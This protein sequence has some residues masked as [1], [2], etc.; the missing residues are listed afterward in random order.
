MSIN[1]LCHLDTLHYFAEKLH[2]SGFESYYLISRFWGVKFLRFSRTTVLDHL[3]NKN[4]QINPSSKYTVSSWST[5]QWQKR[6]NLERSY[7]TFLLHSKNLSITKSKLITSLNI[8]ICLSTPIYTQ[9]IVFP[10][11][12][13]FYNLLAFLSSF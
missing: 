13:C 5:L 1:V 8:V 11:K 10:S 7:F 9:K 12:L 6:S 4:P 2:Q 3:K